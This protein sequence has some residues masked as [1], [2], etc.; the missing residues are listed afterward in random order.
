MAQ[1]RRSKKLNIEAVRT[2]GF[3][4]DGGTPEKPKHDYYY[5]GK[6]MS[7]VT[8]VLG[9]LAKPALI[10]WAAN[11]AT[12]YIREHVEYAIPGQ[13]GGFWAVKPQTVEEARTA[14]A[15]FRDKRASEG[16]DLHGLVEEYVK[17]CIEANDGK[18]YIEGVKEEIVPF[19]Q[20]AIKENIRFLASEE[21][22]YSK[23]LWVAGTFDLLFE[24]D[25]KLIMG[26]L[27]NKKKLYGRDAMFQMAAYSIMWE[28]MHQPTY[29]LSKVFDDT[30]LPIEC[31]EKKIDD[32]C[33]IRLWEDELEAVWSG[34]THGDREGFMAC[35][36]LYRLIK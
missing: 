5:D 15:K 34:D 32:Y 36:K 30:I 21:K 33:V 28:E 11:Q 12:E 31:S 27:K 9:V 23:E 22:V 17:Y 25:G 6:L 2:E 10:Q 13:D 35:L 16:T 29:P 3:Y 24:K 18:P 19:V 26:D 8:T 7:G 14:H 1:L 4:F 20:W